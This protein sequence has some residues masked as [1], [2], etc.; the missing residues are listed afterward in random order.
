MNGV[1]KMQCAIPKSALSAHSAVHFSAAF[2][3]IVLKISVLIFLSLDKMKCMEPCATRL[4]VPRNVRQI[5]FS[6][7][8]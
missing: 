5:L 1:M 3:I 6:V 2:I 8:A 7:T 4:I